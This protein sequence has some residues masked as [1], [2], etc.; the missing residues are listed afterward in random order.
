[1]N[2][3]FE[4]SK[5][6]NYIHCKNCPWNPKKVGPIAFGVSC[7]EHGIQWSLGK[8]A[9]SI[10]VVQ[11][12]AGTTPEKTGRLCFV[13]NSMNPSDKTAQHAYDLWKATISYDVNTTNDKY[14]K[15]HYW[16]NALMHGADKVKHA[17][18]R[19]NN[20]LEDAREHCANI[21]SEQINLLSPKV[22]I[23]NGEIASKSLYDIGLLQYKWNDF[24][25]D[26]DEGIHREIA[27]LPNGQKVIVF[28]TFHTAITPINTHI[29]RMY[30]AGIQAKLDQKLESIKNYSNVIAFLKKYSSYETT[31]KGMRVLLQHWI[32]IGS[33]IRAEFNL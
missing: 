10:Q 12:P 8:K 15:K 4:E 5:S 26:F 32:D 7:E 27:L 31:G 11:D 29:A 19:K 14:L 21:L 25:K 16:T 23:A 20:I 1:M 28:S 30:S 18:L 6:G 22:I 24:K 13:H 9:V 17:S 33:A 3:L 2:N